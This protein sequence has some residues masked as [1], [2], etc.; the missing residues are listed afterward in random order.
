MRKREPALDKARLQ[1]VF[2]DDTDYTSLSS[3]LHFNVYDFT[4]ENSILKKRS[5]GHPACG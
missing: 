3:V 2:S 4:H 1:N 5:H